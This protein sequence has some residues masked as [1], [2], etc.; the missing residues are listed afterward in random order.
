M[1]L[2]TFALPF[3]CG[4]LKSKLQ[5]F[6]SR[7]P[8][9]VLITGIGE[10]AFRDACESFLQ[11]HR[12]DKIIHAGFCAGLHQGLLPGDCLK[13][14][15]KSTE[16]RSLNNWPEVYFHSSQESQLDI[17]QV[18]TAQSLQQPFPSHPKL[19]CVNEPLETHAKKSSFAE[20]YP[21]AI[22]ADMESIAGYQLAK[23]YGLDITWIRVVSDA[24]REDFPIPTEVL[25]PKGSR[26]PSLV[27]I[28]R[29]LAANPARILP[30]CHFVKNSFL[31]RRRLTI[32]VLD[33]LRVK[34][35]D[36]NYT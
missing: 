27:A 7:T 8:L 32:A 21:Q 31:A 19:L 9:N 24:L 5:K 3:E 30:F 28:A 10:A 26:H 11:K 23:K 35:S 25:L 17:T 16:G 12:V 15:W 36:R 22:A 2:L 14:K 6:D 13:G 18:I 29:F 4:L 1:T 20:K 34:K 33:E